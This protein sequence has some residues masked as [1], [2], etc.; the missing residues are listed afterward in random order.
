MHLS[1]LCDTDISECSHIDI[2]MLI[3][4]RHAAESFIY[5]HEY[6]GVEPLRID[7]IEPVQI[8]MD[9]IDCICALET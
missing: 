9:Q 4:K 3:S 8:R 1:N 5:E 2:F 6:V 7:Y